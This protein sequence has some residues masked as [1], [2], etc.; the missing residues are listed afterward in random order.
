MLMISA[1]NWRIHH[2]VVVMLQLTQ[3]LK[4]G[5]RKLLCTYIFSFVVKTYLGVF[6][7]YIYNSLCSCEFLTFLWHLNNNIEMWWY[8]E[9]PQKIIYYWEIDFNHEIYLE[10][11][12]CTA[13]VIP[14]RTPQQLIVELFNTFNWKYDKYYWL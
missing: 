1:S 12:L 14:F 3:D 8:Q 13:C 9:N 5:K 7:V 11:Y 4:H 2:L 6:E 10:M